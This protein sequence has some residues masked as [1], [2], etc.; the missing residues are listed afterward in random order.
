MSILLTN[1]FEEEV[2]FY[3]LSLS[4]I[5]SSPLYKSSSFVISVIPNY[6]SLSLEEETNNL[7]KLLKTGLF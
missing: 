6:V 1:P 2:I 5:F 7:I 3:F 4:R